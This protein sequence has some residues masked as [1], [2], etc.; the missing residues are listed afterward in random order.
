MYNDATKN[1]TLNYLKK[2]KELRL[3]LKPE[4]YDEYSTYAK[5]HGMSLRQFV[6]DAIKE[7]MERME[8][9]K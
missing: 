5:A 7:K 3:W 6:R 4:E 1:A 2:Q 9:Q 8:L